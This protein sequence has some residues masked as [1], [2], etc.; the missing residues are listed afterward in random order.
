[1]SRL[2]TLNA[3]SLRIETNA[4][5][6]IASATSRNVIEGAAVAS[7]NF[8]MG[9]VASNVVSNVVNICSLNVNT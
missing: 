9:I 1:M 6:G 2:Q 8:V 4:S 3:H 7:V 5:V